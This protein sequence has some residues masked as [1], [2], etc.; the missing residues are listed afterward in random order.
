[1]VGAVFAG[2]VSTIA[3]SSAAWGDFTTTVTPFF[4][5]FNLSSNVPLFGGLVQDNYGF[6]PTAAFG[7]WI[8]LGAPQF[9]ADDTGDVF[10]TS[11]GVISIN[12]GCPR[13]PVPGSAT[14]GLRLY[15]DR[16]RQFNK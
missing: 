12:Y 5:D 4:L 10:K 9:N 6:T 11:P 13:S 15:F 2:A 8:A 14:R 16:T 1:L 3:I 7:N